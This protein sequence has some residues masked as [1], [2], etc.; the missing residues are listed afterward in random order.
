MDSL[1]IEIN[2]PSI[3]DLILTEQE[4]EPKFTPN[5]L[6]KLKLNIFGKAMVG[7]YKDEN[8]SGS[9]PLYIFKCQEHGLQLSYPMGWKKK[10]ICIKCLEKT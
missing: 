9:L 2:D 4:E 5:L 3:I 7:K 8:W 1:P 10:L 6:Q